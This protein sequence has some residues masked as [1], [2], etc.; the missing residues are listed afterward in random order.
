M[1][2]SVATLPLVTG[3]R[4]ALMP[5]FFLVLGNSSHPRSQKDLA[6]QDLAINHKAIKISFKTNP[7][8]HWTQIAG[9]GL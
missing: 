6:V 1:P 8:L 9:R 4:R 3:P 2:L 7:F 5:A